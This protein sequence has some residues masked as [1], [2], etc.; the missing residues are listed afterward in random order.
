MPRGRPAAD[1]TAADKLARDQAKADKFVDLASK[2]V[3]EALKRIR[4]IEPLANKSAYYFEPS[5]IQAIYDALGNQVNETMQRFQPNAK[6]SARGFA[7]PVS[8]IAA[9]T[10]AEDQTEE[11]T[12]QPEGSADEPEGS[13]DQPE[14]PTE[15]PQETPSEPNRAAGGRRNR[16]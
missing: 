16:G 13:T 10:P 14:G 5:Q 4:L 12:D 2:R 11:Q 3:E 1:L 15:Q 8:T 9:P 6:V 7:V